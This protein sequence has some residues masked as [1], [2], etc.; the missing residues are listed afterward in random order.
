MSKKQAHPDIQLFD[1]INGAV[2][3]KSAK[4]IEAHL[5]AC[6]D[7][8]SVARLVGALKESASEPTNEGLSEI[9]NLK[10]Q[11]SG[12]H[13]DISTLASYFYSESPRTQSPS[14]ASHVV[15]CRS[16]AEALAQ[17]AR[18]ERAAAEYKPVREA[19]GEVPA[20][21]WEMIRD[22]EDSIFAT[23]KPPT[24]AVSEELLERL[25]SLVSERSNEVL[26]LEGSQP[27]SRER[28]QV[29]VVN[30]SGEVR[31]VEI[32]EREVDATG[33]RVLKH[34][35]GSGRFDDRR[36]HVLLDYG[37]DEP[38]VASGMVRRGTIRLPHET[39]SPDKPVRENYF[40]VED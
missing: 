14:V 29:L 18:A 16:C 13:P 6:D 5:S 34:L 35:E 8:A 11:I 21:A 36:I 33:E 1:F 40:I 23:L 27:E 26:E 19:L 38:L 30:R 32:F 10:S 3:E 9:S 37:E 20:T 2:D 12:E 4:V 24:E 17:Y 39:R 22:W 31:S 28:V 15:L 25:S 7:C